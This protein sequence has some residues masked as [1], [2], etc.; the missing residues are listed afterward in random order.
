ML[1]RDEPAVPPELTEV[2]A[3]TRRQIEA[4]HSPPRLHRDAHPKMHGCLQ[5]MLTLHPDCPDTLKQG[6]FASVPNTGYKAWFAIPTRSTF[7][8][9][10]RLK[11][12]AWR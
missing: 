9:T 10:S 5:A 2:I 7:N 12:A 8:M 1:V 4:E 11:R 3:E 6:V